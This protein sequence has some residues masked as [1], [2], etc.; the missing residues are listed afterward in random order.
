MKKIKLKKSVVILIVSILLII[1][2]F[3]LYGYSLKGYKSNDE[4]TFT[5]RSGASKKEIV[6]D[7]KSA[8]L[9]RSEVS[10]LIYLVLNQ[11]SLQAG[12][13][14]FSRNMST[15]DIIK[16]IVKGDIFINSVTITLNEGK[17]INDFISIITNN[18]PYTEEEV[19]TAINDE[20]L[21]K[22]LIEKYDFLTDEILNGNIYYALEG[23]LF[24]D[25][26]EF[27]EDASIEDIITVMLNNTKLKLDSVSDELN[28]SSYTVHEI[29]TMASIAELEAVTK[30]DRE[31]VAQVIYKRLSMGKGLGMD[32]TTYY[33]VKKT[34][35]EDLTMNDL[36]S[37]S[38]Y[39]TSESNSYMAGKLPVGPICN[40]SL[41][42]I[43]AVLNPSETD[44]LYFYANIKTH[45]VLF[46]STYEEF[47]AIQKEVG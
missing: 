32:V 4:V 11:E 13:Y 15:P 45:E 31:S 8:G 27:Y 14:E 30:S 10:T 39:N 28:N 18:F 5:V 7:L 29:L 20:E 42:S 17:N 3:L 23:Y 21:L 44:Y 41:E 36:R 40:P 47:V 12:T 22:N 38:L 26:Y 6:H 34:L 37:T 33:A 35:G 19:K 25:T 9:I 46:A 1:F 43:L 16:K 2:L 24:P